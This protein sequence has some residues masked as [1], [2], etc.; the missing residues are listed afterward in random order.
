MYIPL[1]LIQQTQNTYKKK[2]HSCKRPCHKEQT[3]NIYTESNKAL[4]SKQGFASYTWNMSKAVAKKIE[5]KQK[6][7]H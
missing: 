6:S 2:K 3:G 5:K 7:L 4:A 1:Y